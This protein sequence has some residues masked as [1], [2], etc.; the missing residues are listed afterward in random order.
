MKEKKRKKH[1]ALLLV[2]ISH[3]KETSEAILF[4]FTVDKKRGKERETSKRA[5]AVFSALPS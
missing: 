5:A 1:T 2:V 4:S 3:Q